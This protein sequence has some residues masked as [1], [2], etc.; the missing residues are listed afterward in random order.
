[1]IN[2]YVSPIISFED[3]AQL[4]SFDKEH[5]KV[6]KFSGGYFILKEDSTESYFLLHEIADYINKT[7]ANKQYEYIFIV[8]KIVSEEGAYT[9]E[10]HFINLSFLYLAT[11]QGNLTIDSQFY[12]KDIE[13]LYYIF[14]MIKLFLSKQSEDINILIISTIDEQELSEKLHFDKF[15][16][17]SLND[18]KTMLLKLSIIEPINKKIKN[19]LFPLILMS[20]AVYA[21]F[22]AYEKYKDDVDRKNK[23]E[24]SMY[25]KKF[26]KIDIK[27][28]QLLKEIHKVEA[29]S[30]ED[31]YNDGL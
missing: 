6:K 31:I 18:T 8:N 19:Y 20:M 27:N 4:E 30:L 15:S 17:L 12:A 10:L 29:Y 11:T 16:L 26:S 22:T 25:E 9:Y 3:Y 13:K 14:N 2:A 24:L 1:L 21:I 28:K 7:Q 23:I 5:M